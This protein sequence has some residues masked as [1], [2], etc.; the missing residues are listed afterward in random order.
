MGHIEYLNKNPDPW[1]KHVK[2]KTHQALAKDSLWAHK[3]QAKLLLTLIV[4]TN[5][6]M[7][8]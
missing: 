8:H 2:L 1:A 7:G 5:M 6:Q 3:K 4:A